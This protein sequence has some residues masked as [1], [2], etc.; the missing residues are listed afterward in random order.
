MV[1]WFCGIDYSMTH[2]AMCC[3]HTT[4]DVLRW[5][6]MSTEKSKLKSDSNLFSAHIPVSKT[7]AKDIAAGT[8]DDSFDRYNLIAEYFMKIIDVLKPKC[9]FL[10]GY[11]FGST[12]QIFNI[13]E[14]TGI[15]KSKL[16]DAGHKVLTLPPTTVK[17]Y[18]TGKGTASK[19]MMKDCFMRP[20]TQLKKI[21]FE[22]RVT[23]LSKVAHYKERPFTDLIDA[24][25]VLRY[26]MSSMYANSG[27]NGAE[28]LSDPPFLPV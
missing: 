9:V 4:D 6:Y 17:K 23:D 27:M 28:I 24:Y 1:V 12:G 10:E 2:P 13:A 22:N 21:V 3:Y 20:S 7:S 26:G 25:Y 15:L 18:A 11:S 14:N 19:Q 16:F 8:I 5:Y